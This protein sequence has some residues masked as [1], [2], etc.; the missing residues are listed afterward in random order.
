GAARSGHDAPGGAALAPPPREEER[1]RWGPRPPRRGGAMQTTL[2]ANADV[3]TE[4]WALLRNMWVIQV[5]PSPGEATLLQAE[6][7]GGSYDAATDAIDENELKQQLLRF[8]AD[9]ERHV[10]DL[11]G[12]VARFGGKAERAPDLKG[13]ARKTMTRVA[14]LVG[15]EAVLRA[16]LSNERATND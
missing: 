1:R 13:M 16:M 14:G 2:T 3:S 12:L 6:V 15:T 5:S 11:R 10:V 8:R 9:H 7:E 4:P